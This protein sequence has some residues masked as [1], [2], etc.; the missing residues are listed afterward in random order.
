MFLFA[1]QS[2]KPLAGRSALPGC[3]QSALGWH[4]S[5]LGTDWVCTTGIFSVCYSEDRVALVESPLDH[6]FSSQYTPVGCNCLAHADYFKP[7]GII[8]GSH[9]SH[10]K[11][12]KCS[13]LQHSF[14]IVVISN[15]LCFILRVFL[16]YAFIAGREKSSML[17][18]FFG[19]DSVY[20]KALKDTSTALFY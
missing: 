2:A 12:I 3:N 1:E 17:W 5:V 20:T 9:F 15:C 16:I 19:W 6:S 14:T 11:S 10:T 7:P 4:N 13:W 18:S 8:P